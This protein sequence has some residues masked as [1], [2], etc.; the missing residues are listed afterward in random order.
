MKTAGI[1]QDVRERTLRLLLALGCFAILLSGAPAAAKEKGLDVLIA[2]DALPSPEG[3]RPKPGEP[4]HYILSLARDTLGDAVAGVKMPQP[5]VV[6][7]A[8]AA[9][10]KKQG[11]IRTEVGGPLPQ[12]VILAV[13]GDA[14]FEQ[15]PLPPGVNPLLEQEFGPFLRMVNIRQILEQH[16]LSQKVPATVET[17]FPEDPQGSREAFP[18]SDPDVNEAR[19]LVVGEAIRLRERGSARGRDRGKILSLVGAGKVER[20]VSER[21]ISSTAAERIVWVTRTNQLYVT[22]QAYDALRWKEKQ[23]VLLWRTTMLIDWREDFGKS[24][25]EMLAQAGPVFGTDVALPG[26]VNTAARDGKV[27]IGQATVVSEKESSP[28][29][30]SVK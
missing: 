29:N 6:E 1:W 12:I 10:L 2:A 24:L 17:L 8:V 21:T 16:N 25:A 18:S 3:F 5:S 9:E 22:V 11:F 19:D 27:E 20:A 14:N 30:S 23:R 7:R 28:K 13:V 26:F 4:I 15:P